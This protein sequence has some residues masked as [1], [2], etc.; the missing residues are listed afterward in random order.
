MSNLTRAYQ[1][2]FASSAGG[3][4]IGEFGSLAAG[5]A[6]TTTDPEAAQSLS[7]WLGGWFSAILGPNA[8]AIEDMNAVCFVLSYQIAY[9]LQ[10]GVPQW[11]ALTTYYIGD[12]VNVA[13]VLYVSLT[14]AN[15]NNVTTDITNWGLSSSTFNQQSGAPTVQNLNDN[16]VVTHFPAPLHKINFSVFEGLSGLTNNLINFT[17]PGDYILQDNT[18]IEVASGIADLV[19][20]G[21]GGVDSFT[22][23]LLHMDGIN[24]ATSF[25]D[26]SAS[27]HVSTANGNSHV[28]TAVVHFGTGSMNETNSG[29]NYLSVTGTQADWA[30]GTADYTIDF[31]LNFTPHASGASMNLMGNSS[32]NVTANNWVMLFNTGTAGIQF[33]NNGGPIIDAAPGGGWNDNQWYH[34]ALVRFG[35]NTTLYADGVAIQTVATAYNMSDSSF[36]LTIGGHANGSTTNSLNGYMDEVRVSKGIARWTSNFTPPIISYGF[37]YPSGQSYYVTTATGSQIDTSDISKIVTCAIT[38]SQPANTLVHGLV[39]FDG[40][41]NWQK[42]NGSA[43]VFEVNAAG[44]GAYDFIV[45]GNTMAQIQTGLTNLTLNGSLTLDFVFGLSTTDVLVTPSVDQVTITDNDLL[46]MC[47]L[48]KPGSSSDYGVRRLSSTTTRFTKQTAGPSIVVIN[49]SN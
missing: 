13:G 22:K 28:S 30:F 49:A 45:N 9:L 16:I 27:V 33:S 23:L 15:L 26:S 48:G 12:I 19:N 37:S 43:W 34:V 29:D 11:N 36:P 39:S 5:S 31:W 25:P 44:L 38:F 14:N 47:S 10:K 41:A 8:P 18:K 6:V 32:A 2:I 42:W 4:Q 17:T 1:R 3:S 35:G 24:G 46:D 20:Q 21:N 7:N 40:R